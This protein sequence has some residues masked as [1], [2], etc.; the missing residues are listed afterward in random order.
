MVKLTDKT[1]WSAAGTRAVK[2][3]CQSLAS[4][5][6]AGFVITP[7]MIQ[8]A[9]W[10]IVYALVAWLATGALTGV[11]SLLTSLAGIPETSLKEDDDEQLESEVE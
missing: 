1:W 4:T 5:L 6:P 11:A 3:T 10:T 8:N 2:S 9:N 7:V